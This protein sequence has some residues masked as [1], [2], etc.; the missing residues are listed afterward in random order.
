MVSLNS[1]THPKQNANVFASAGSGKTWLLITRICRLLLSGVEPQHILAITFTRKSAAEMRVRLIEKLSNWAVMSDDELTSELAI[2][3]EPPHPEK[4]HVARTLY[5]KLLFSDQTIRINTFHA[6]CEEIIRAFPLESE[7]PTTFDLTEIPH[8]Y[9]NQAW[10]RL[11]AESEKA[12]KSKL[13]SSLNTLFDFCYGIQNT[14]N[15][16]YKF[17]DA[18]SE[19]KAYTQQASDAVTFAYENLEANI[20]KPSSSEYQIWVTSNTASTDLTFFSRLLATSPTASYQQWANKITSACT[21]KN[22]T[23]EKCFTLLKDAFLTAKNEPRQLKFS[24]AWQKHLSSEDQ[25]NLQ[26]KHKHISHLLT[27]HLDSQIHST[28]LEANHAWFFSGREFIQQYQRIKFE[29]GVIDFNDLEWETYH[30]LRHDDHALWVQYKLG[31]RLHHFLV[32][33]FQDTNPIQWHLLKSLIDSSND[34]ND[35]E[36]NSLFLVGDVKQSIYRFRGANPEIQILANEWSQQS[37]NSKQYSNDHSW[38]SSPAVINCV[39]QLFSHETISESFPSFNPH[40]VQHSDHWGYVCVHPLVEIEESISPKNFRNPLTDAR[41]NDELSASFQEGALIG[42]EILEIINSNTPIYNANPVRP[43][44]FSDVLI[45]TQTRSHLEQLKGGLQSKGIPFHSNDATHLL[46]YLEIKDLLSLL[47]ILVDPNC[48]LEFAHVLRSPIFSISHDHLIK[49]VRITKHTWK[50]KLEEFIQREPDNPSVNFAHQKLASWQNLVDRIPVH[51]LLSHIYSDINIQS[52]YRYA[53]PI[54]DSDHICERINQLLHQSLE[55]DSGRFSSVSRFLR[56]IKES[57]PEVLTNIDNNQSNVVTLMTVHGAKGLEAPIVFIADSGPTSEPPEQFKNIICWPASSSQPTLYMLGCKQSGMSK[58]SKQTVLEL[59]Q[60]SNEKLN[61]LYVAMTRAKQILIVTGIHSKKSSPNNWHDQICAGLNIDSKN[62]WEHVVGVKP[63]IS[64]LS[65]I[66]A[67]QHNYQAHPL[68]FEKFSCE[69]TKTI[70]FEGADNIKATEGTIIHK[71]LEILSDTPTISLQALS[72]RIQFESDSA[73]TVSEIE[74]FKNEAIACLEE[75]S[76]KD[77]FSPHHNKKIFNEIS[78]ANTDASN[79][80]NI[81]DKL[82]VNNETAWIIDF[83]TQDKVSRQ[84]AQKSARE[85]IPQL[86][87]YAADISQ[88]YPTLSIRCSIVFTKIPLL[89]DVELP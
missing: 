25:D 52:L 68:L 74:R 34:I 9:R 40:S 38:R 88:L 56:K 62:K 18:R 58:S 16:L 5:E 61:L 37:L 17:L 49:I 42:E 57:N 1:S 32:D 30:L 4:L 36:S 76:I 11:L 33:E 53:S 22:L 65:S 83:K 23:S 45:L 8:V 50:Q 44:Q 55:I 89:V 43:A 86:Q 2:I 10:H 24:K 63:T 70:T 48:D 75:P 26:L 19:W 35:S 69:P 6:F 81:I 20:G 80:I 13:R 39:N 87:R 27:E 85:Y 29:H 31:Q 79:Q 66:P 47:K 54:S 60:S 64:T 12:G 73:I 51:D 82:I 59:E 84:N 77:A 14:K 28:L 21:E 41:S 15:A 78:V 7:L 3:D 46:D 71:I 67:Q 72:N